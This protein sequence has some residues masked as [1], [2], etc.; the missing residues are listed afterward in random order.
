MPT[1]DTDPIAAFRSVLDQAAVEPDATQQAKLYVAALE[2]VPALQKE[3]RLRRQA[4]VLRMRE[5]NPTWSHAEVG[6][7]LGLHRTRAAHIA[8]GDTR[9]GNAIRRAASDMPSGEG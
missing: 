3:L 5:E 6:R 7:R 1:P 9:T 2:A 8:L 4:A